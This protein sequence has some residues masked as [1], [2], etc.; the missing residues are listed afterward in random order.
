MG[1]AA[2]GAED[3]FYGEDVSHTPRAIFPE[4]IDHIAIAE[5]GIAQLQEA[6]SAKGLYEKGSLVLWSGRGDEVGIHI[7]GD[8]YI[9][10]ALDLDARKQKPEILVK[11]VIVD[12]VDNIIYKGGSLEKALQE[13]TAQAEYW[14]NVGYFPL[15]AEKMA[16]RVEEMLAH[17]R[18]AD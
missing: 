12:K 6:F 10:V 9:E 16:E 5:N 1:R 7:E 3:I 8:S 15:S 17:V 4:E 18:L 2:R 13:G 14:G 11:V